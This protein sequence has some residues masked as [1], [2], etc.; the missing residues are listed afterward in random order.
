MQKQ[1]CKTCMRR[2]KNEASLEDHLNSEAH[3][4]Q[5]EAAKTKKKLDAARYIK[6]ESRGEPA[7]STG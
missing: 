5:V 3:R 6:P 1:A 4:L 2:F 7:R